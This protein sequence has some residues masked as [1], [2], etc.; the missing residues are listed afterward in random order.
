MPRTEDPVSVLPLYTPSVF[1]SP[2]LRAAGDSA[3]VGECVGRVMSQSPLPVTPGEQTAP[4]VTCIQVT[5]RVVVHSFQHMVR[6]TQ[7]FTNRYFYNR[8]IV[9][10]SSEAMAALFLEGL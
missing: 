2:L 5:P 3:Q 9:T 10:R 1:A 8:I 7:R 4:Q 6:I